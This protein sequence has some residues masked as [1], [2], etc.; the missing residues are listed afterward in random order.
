[1]TYKPSVLLNGFHVWLKWNLLF[2]LFNKPMLSRIIRHVRTIAKSYLLASSFLSVPPARNNS[3]PTELSFMKLDTLVFFEN[4]LGKFKFHWNLI[5]KSGTLHDDKYRFMVIFRSIR[6]RMRK[7]QKKV[8]EKIKIHFMFSN[9]LSKIVPFKRQCGK[10]LQSRA[11]HRWKY[12]A[13]ALHAGYLRLQIH[14]E[15][16]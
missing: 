9:G 12:G 16:M 2:L 14:T 4:L 10:I 13:C 7:L 15:N 1:M 11:G 5:R 6:L 8:V 3:A